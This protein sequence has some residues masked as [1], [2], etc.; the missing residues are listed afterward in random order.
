VTEE[1]N[2]TDPEAARVFYDLS[3]WNFEQQAEL[4]SALA[5]AEIPHGWE[6]DELVVPEAF[7]STTD[8]V[9]ADLE[10]RLDIAPA[11]ESGDGDA[12]GDGGE[13]AVRGLVEGES[14]TDYDL[15]DWDEYERTLVGESLRK[16]NIPFS[17]DYA[18]LSVP[19]SDE[20][21]VDAILDE[22]ETG[23][24][25]P[26]AGDSEDGADDELPFESLNSFFLAGERLRK[27]QRD[28]DGLE[29]LL[30]ALEMADPNRPPSGV[31]LRVWRRCCEL[32][33]ELAD[34]LVD[35]NDDDDLDAVIPVAEA[36]HDLLRPLI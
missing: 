13:V 9:F 23:K 8:A 17:W 34:L 6:G 12:D 27:D 3:Q 29:R 11:S 28:A 26:V 16:A 5:D 32:A 7:E 31:E 35:G 18:V 24:I 15:S 36:L 10:E 2:P 14:L 33:E 22:V 4:A 19:T 25:I 1:W 30:E 21:R 20:A